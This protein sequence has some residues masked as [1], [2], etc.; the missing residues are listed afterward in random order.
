MLPWPLDV[1]PAADPLEEVVVK[2]RPWAAKWTVDNADAG[3]LSDGLASLRGRIAK[4]LMF[5]NISNLPGAANGFVRIARAYDDVRSRGC[6]NW[7]ASEVGNLHARR[8]RLF[9]NPPLAGKG[10]LP[11]LP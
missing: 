5:S 2:A 4:W 6:D 8:F 9:R 11:A 3:D 10:Q 7:R 1:L